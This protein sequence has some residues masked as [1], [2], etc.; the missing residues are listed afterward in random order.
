MNREIN[1]PFDDFKVERGELNGQPCIFVT[2]KAT[3]VRT[4]A[5]EEAGDVANTELAMTRLRRNSKFKKYLRD[6]AKEY[7][8]RRP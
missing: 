2:H 1:L 4:R 6:M 5:F 8:G 3:G 7:R